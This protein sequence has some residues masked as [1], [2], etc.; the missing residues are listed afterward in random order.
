M[1]KWK[2]NRMGAE[3]GVGVGF[4]LQRWLF[5]V[6]KARANLV[7]R[8]TL[9]SPLRLNLVFTQQQTIW[10]IQYILAKGS[11]S[12]KLRIFPRVNALE[13][14][15]PYPIYEKDFAL[16]Q[17]KCVILRNVYLFDQIKVKWYNQC[18][19]IAPMLFPL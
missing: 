13:R 9:D 17:Y 14:T 2:S 19:L 7:I 3:V 10:I 12:L 18:V 15:H 1:N 11:K 6:E 16:Q 5:Q 4:V 8:M